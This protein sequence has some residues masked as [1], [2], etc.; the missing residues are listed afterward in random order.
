MTEG[1]K[2]SLQRCAIISVVMSFYRWGARAVGNVSLGM[3]HT[4]SNPFRFS[5]RHWHE[6]YPHKFVKYSFSFIVKSPF[7]PI[8]IQG[9]FQSTGLTSRWQPTAVSPSDN[10][11]ERAIR[12]ES[13][14][15]YTHQLDWFKLTALLC[16]LPELS[17]LQLIFVPHVQ[18]LSPTM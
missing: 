9:R 4:S 5:F 1:L 18:R 15:F 11:T 2:T 8:G 12:M 17:A 3:I 16:Y 14:R 6:S 10:W 7:H 13:E